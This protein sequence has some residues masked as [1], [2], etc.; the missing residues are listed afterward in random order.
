MTDAPIDPFAQRKAEYAA[1]RRP[2]LL[3]VG[4]AWFLSLD[5]IGRPDEPRFQEARQA[6]LTTA[7][8]L[9]RQAKAEGRPFRLSKLEALWSL[10]PGHH[11]F[12]AAPSQAWQ[13]TLCLQAPD[14]VG[15]NMLLPLKQQLLSR[16]ASKLIRRVKLIG[17]VE[18]R[19]AQM[20]LVGPRE[21]I[22]RRLGPLDAFIESR[23][24]TVVGRRHEVHLSD[25]RRADPA[26]VRTLVRYPVI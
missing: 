2:K 7:R 18:G 4:D 14:F 9:Q 13:W 12:D 19:S 20:L 1:P 26:K 15:D 17:F 3:D 21:G 11:D 16:G 5:G 24:L 8:A 23:G 6:L 22:H 10:E 25:E